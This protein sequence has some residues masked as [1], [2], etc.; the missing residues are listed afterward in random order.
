M[1]ALIAAA[2]R[3]LAAG[4]VL[5]R[6]PMP[7]GFAIDGLES[8]GGELFDCSGG[9]GK[10]RVVRCP[11]PKRRADRPLQ[12]ANAP[13]RA[14]SSKRTTRVRIASGGSSGSMWRQ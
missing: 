1:D 14:I 5:E 11:K 2:G 6:L 12:S 3:L 4:D 8:G 7:C 10:D 13:S 9:S